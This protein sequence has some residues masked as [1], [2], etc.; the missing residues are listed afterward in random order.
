MICQFLPF[1]GDEVGGSDERC[2]RT[3]NFDAK[4]NSR[5][6]A[7]CAFEMPYFSP[8]PAVIKLIVQ[9]GNTSI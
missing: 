2:P 9:G 5:S 4:K 6:E 7:E 1:Q 3:S 8:C